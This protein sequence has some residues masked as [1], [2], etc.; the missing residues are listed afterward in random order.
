MRIDIQDRIIL[1]NSSGALKPKNINRNTENDFETEMFDT[2]LNRLKAAYEEKDVAKM[3][4]TID[5][6]IDFA[7]DVPKARSK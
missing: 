1:N 3:K 6:L 2:A 5:I 7:N 4:Q